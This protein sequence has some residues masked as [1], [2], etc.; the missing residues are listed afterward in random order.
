[1][2]LGVGDL[3]AGIRLKKSGNTLKIN[4]PKKSDPLGAKP[5]VYI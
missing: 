5:H 2:T 3:A 1:M 4:D